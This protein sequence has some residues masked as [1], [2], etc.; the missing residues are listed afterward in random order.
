M[1]SMLTKDAVATVLAENQFTK[2]RLA[3]ELDMASSVSVSNWL[4]GTRMSKAAADVFKAKFSIEVTDAYS[5]YKVP[6]NRR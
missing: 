2:Y 5:A 3:K 1:R 6:R 4:L